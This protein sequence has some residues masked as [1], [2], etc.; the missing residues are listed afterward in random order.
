[1]ERF[2]SSGIEVFTPDALNQLEITVAIVVAFLEGRR[3][4]VCS[5]VRTAYVE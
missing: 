1:M 3:S 5:L 4:G 2:E